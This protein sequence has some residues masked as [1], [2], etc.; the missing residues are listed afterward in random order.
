MTFAMPGYYMEN[1]GCRATQ[2]DAAA[3]EQ[4]LAERGFRSVA[5]AGADLFVVNTCTVTASADSRARQ[6]IRAFHRRNPDARILVTGCYAQ[7]APEELAELAGVRWVVGNAHQSEIAEIA[8]GRPSGAT[9][10]FVPL[11]ALGTGLGARRGAA[12]GTEILTGGLDEGREVLV[13][14]VEQGGT[15]TRP[16]L[17]I[18]EG[19][20]HR[21]A[22]CVI[23][24]VRGRSRSLAPGRV[25]EEIERLARAGAREV[26]LSGI[27]LGS[28]GRDL[29]PRSSLGALLE[30]VMEQTA[31]ERLRLSS[32]EPMHLTAD[33]IE[34]MASSERIAPH[35]HIPLQSGS[36][37][38]LAAMHRWYRA[39][40][41][42]RR[43]ELIAER[44]PDA[45][46]GADVIAGF[47]GETEADHRATL[48]LVERL[49]FSY[50]HVFSFSARP[51]TEAARLNEPVRPE[52]IRERSREL[53]ALATEKAATFR[54]RQSGRV[55]R[56]LTLQTTRDGATVALT[57]N[58]LTA[59][60]PGRWP[61]NRWLTLRLRPNG[62]GMTG[63]PVAAGA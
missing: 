34:R 59:R 7:R 32:L 47:P 5:A 48:A 49:P 18:Q 42:A 35:F 60:V 16:T 36:D 52:A 58:Y 23:P 27:N 8:G 12:G 46:I 6:A 56:A 39:E 57:G 29:E 4:R 31:V 3:M 19:C 26:V 63:E 21:C 50:L 11:G 33:L 28:Y 24:H 25:V 14:P 22:Y 43:I 13:G 38:V 2:A 10:G 54:A 9:G 51:G 41:Y 44:M 53:R 30:R 40:H 45:A 1:F 20:N 15:H 61:A 37:C 55:T 62:D 17:K